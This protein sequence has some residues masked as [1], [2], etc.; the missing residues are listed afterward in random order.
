MVSCGASP[1]N[2]V[3]TLRIHTKIVTRVCESNE[4]A[5]CDMLEPALASKRSHFL[6]AHSAQ[7]ATVGA[8]PRL[9]TAGGTRPPAAPRADA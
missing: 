1:Q 6:H 8:R 3:R 7:T 2:F 5:R 9:A 4:I